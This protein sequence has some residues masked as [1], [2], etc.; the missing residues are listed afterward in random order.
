MVYQPS[1]CS[2]IEALQT[3]T[4]FA[5]I[6]AL[7]Q[8]HIVCGALNLMVVMPCSYGLVGE[9]GDDDGFSWSTCSF[10]HHIILVGL[11]IFSYVFRVI[12][13]H[14]GLQ[15]H[16]F[17]TWALGGCFVISAWLSYWL[18][19]DVGG[20]ST[21][22]GIHVSL[23]NIFIKDFFG[24]HLY[25]FEYFSPTTTYGFFLQYLWCFELWACDS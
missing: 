8:D 1:S 24:S 16:H 18:N 12:C 3:S 15:T 25:L 11:T 2:P 4:N 10:L 23:S 20:N 14:F 19:V 22:L 6:V 17:F 9:D 13:G 7:M 5:S 21:F